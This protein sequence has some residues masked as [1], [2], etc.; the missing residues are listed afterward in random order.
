MK[1]CGQGLNGKAAQHLAIDPSG[2]AENIFYERGKHG[3]LF[4]FFHQENSTQRT[5]HFSA[6]SHS[7]FASKRLSSG[8]SRAHNKLLQERNVGRFSGAKRM[9]ILLVSDRR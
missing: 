7:R 3:S 6:T 1:A 5:A 2:L 8:T 9:L 4:Q